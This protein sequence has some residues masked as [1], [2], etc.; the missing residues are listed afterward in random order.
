MYDPYIWGNS[1]PVEGGILPPEPN[2]TQVASIFSIRP[3]DDPVG[4]GIERKATITSSL[5]LFI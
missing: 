4:W 5:A 1:S 2:W 3:V